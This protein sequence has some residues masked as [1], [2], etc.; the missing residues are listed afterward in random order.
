MDTPEL[1]E[2]QPG[3]LGSIMCVDAGES[4]AKLRLRRRSAGMARA[5]FGKDDLVN[6][7][8]DLPLRSD[9]A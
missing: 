8:W 3:D 7:V 1:R 4:V 5:M 6:Q 2:L 9:V